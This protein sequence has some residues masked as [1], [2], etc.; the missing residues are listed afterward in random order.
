M[1][2]T[3]RTD[4]HVARLRLDPE[5]SGCDQ[6]LSFARQLETELAE[7]KAEC[8]RLQAL[9]SWAHTC[10]HHTDEQRSRAER[11]SVCATAELARL[12]AELADEK[13]L[14][15][16]TRTVV[17]ELNTICTDLRNAGGPPFIRSEAIRLLREDQ[18]TLRAEVER[19]TKQIK[20]DNRAYGCELRDPN[21]TIWEQAAKDHARAERAEAELK[22]SRYETVKAAQEGLRECIRAEH[23]EA[24]LAE[25]K[26]ERETVAEASLRS[27]ESYIDKLKQFAERAEKAEAECLEQARL[28]GKSGEREAD[29]LGKID[30][31]NRVIER[32]SVQFFHDGTDGE[33]A[34]KMLNVLN[35]AK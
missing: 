18:V 9:G 15:T 31:L 25:A 20:D 35:E 24:A 29:L 27:L 4:A 23:A 33:A 10:I 12:R 6:T 17:E 30:R 22:A 2:T 28:L 14:H 1:S 3:P 16:Q 11:C 21:G 19:L 34:A 5:A 13:N 8:E 32:A 26:V 7:A